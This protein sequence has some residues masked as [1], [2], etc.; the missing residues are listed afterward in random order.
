MIPAHRKHTI[1]AYVVKSV[2]LK[3]QEPGGRNLAPGTQLR[4]LSDR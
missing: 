1:L 2:K 4:R 3:M